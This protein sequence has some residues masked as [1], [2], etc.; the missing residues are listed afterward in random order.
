MQDS[1]TPEQTKKKAEARRVAG[2]LWKVRGFSG[3]ENGG[4]KSND[5]GKEG[6]KM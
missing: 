2:K 5:D 3:E 1:V 6:K 4:E